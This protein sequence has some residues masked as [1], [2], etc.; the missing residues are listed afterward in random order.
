MK[1]AGNQ[2]GVFERVEGSGVWYARYRVKG[3]LHKEIA[4][5]KTQALKLYK[6]RVGDAIQGRSE[7]RQGNAESGAPCPDSA[8]AG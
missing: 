3:V 8:A 5:T 6:L 7:G 1:R 4:G 2:R